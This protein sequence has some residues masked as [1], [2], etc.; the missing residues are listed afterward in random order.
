MTAAVAKTPTRTLSLRLG[1]LM[2]SAWV[3]TEKV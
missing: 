1:T 2:S 3:A